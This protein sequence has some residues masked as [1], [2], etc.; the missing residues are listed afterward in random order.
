MRI[1]G[2]ARWSGIGHTW[3]FQGILWG[4]PLGSF[5]RTP[6]EFPPGDTPG[7]HPGARAGGL[8][9]RSINHDLE[10]AAGGRHSQSS[11][12]TPEYSPEQTTKRTARPRPRKPPEESRSPPPPAGRR[13]LV[14]RRHIFNWKNQNNLLPRLG[15]PLGVSMGGIL[16]RESSG[17]DPRGVAYGGETAWGIY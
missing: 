17:G 7:D 3:G 12:M 6:A 4:G 9:G 15:G 1:S 11:C 2:G 8:F 10:G 16:F 14:A 5:W 13:I